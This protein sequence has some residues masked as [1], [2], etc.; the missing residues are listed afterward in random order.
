[1][2]REKWKDILEGIG[3]VA[4]IGSLIFVG[5][6]SRNSSRQAA[7]T[8]QA[9]EISAYQDLMSNV[10]ELNLLGLQ[11]EH[12]AFV[13][14]RIFGDQGDLETL[15]EKRALFLLFRHGDMAYFMYERGA[16]SEDRL[17][18]ALRPLQLHTPLFN[19][20]WDQ[21]K[22]AFTEDYQNYIDNMIAG[23]V[24]NNVH[25]AEAFVDTFYSFDSD[26]LQPVLSTARDSIPRILFYQGWAEGGNYEVIERMPCNV[27]SEEAVSCS[28]TVK[29]DL[30][31]ALGIGINVTD[32]FHLT[33]AYGQ[34]VSVTYSSNDPQAYYDAQEWVEEN[35]PELIEEPCKRFF[36]G[37]LTPGDC[38]RAM[39]Q[40]YSEFAA[41]G[42]DSEDP[43]MPE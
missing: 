11:N 8:T 9:L 20:F 21:N 19:E 10:E 41:S 32:T 28:I 14:A 4:I 3:F 37:G 26:S 5:I 35:R 40:G 31:G 22:F 33:F 23:I 2:S 6:E 7:L 38:V 42:R 36:D 29:D 27:E 12:A 18:S 1:M 15:S 30:I 43:Q 24:E 39:V 13:L 16:I 34:I 25:S 17:R